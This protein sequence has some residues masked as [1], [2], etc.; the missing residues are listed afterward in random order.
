MKKPF[1]ISRLLHVGHYERNHFEK[2]VVYIQVAYLMGK[3]F[4]SLGLVNFP[5]K[6]NGH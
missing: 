5:F 3:E 4:K 2:I 1:L 6:N